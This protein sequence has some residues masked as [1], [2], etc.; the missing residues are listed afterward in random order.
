MMREREEREGGKRDL[1]EGRKVDG[2]EEGRRKGRRGGRKEERK[3]ERQD[4]P[5]AYISSESES[6][7]SLSPIVEIKRMNK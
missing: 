1:K 3:K 5:E 7:D 2:G 6:L 4:E